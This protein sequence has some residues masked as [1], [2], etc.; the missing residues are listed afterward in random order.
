MR[1]VHRN[2][3]GRDRRSYRIVVIGDHPNTAR[4]L[5]QKARMAEKGD[6]NCLLCR[7]SRKPQRSARKDTG[8][9]R[10]RRRRDHED[11]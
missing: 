7:R 8:A 6:R 11:E 5:D 10:L 3:V 4:A 2:N 1:I 9:R